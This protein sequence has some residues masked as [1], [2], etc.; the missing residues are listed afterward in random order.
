[1]AI[2][3]P[4][5]EMLADW[6]TATF[7]T[8]PP[9]ELAAATERDIAA[10]REARPEVLVEAADFG[11]SEASEF[12][13]QAAVSKFGYVNE[14]HKLYIGKAFTP[15]Q[16]ADWWSVQTFGSL[17]Y[18][19]VGVHHTAIPDRTT[20]IGLQHL[21]NTFA[22]FKNEHGWPAGKGPH[23][24]LRSAR[25]GKVPGPV[26]YVG[27][28]P[29]SDGIGISYRNF[30]YLHI[31]FIDRFTYYGMSEEDFDLYQY[32]LGIV[33]GQRGIPL[34]HTGGDTSPGRGWD[35]P[36]SPMDG[37]LF[38]RNAKT[39]IKDCPGAMV[40]EVQF[41]K[42]MN[43]A[44]NPYRAKPGGG[45]KPQPAPGGKSVYYVRLKDSLPKDKAVNAL[46]TADAAK[47]EEDRLRKNH[48]IETYVEAPKAPA[49]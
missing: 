15:E 49:G 27:T 39:D 37:Y 34:R 10:L 13:E 33:C 24:W 19:G 32:V 30:R 40:H 11:G 5:R 36:Q 25:A 41:G 4:R 12:V 42:E 46:P 17:P 8:A 18:N 6:D 23:L 38:H 1:M 22:Y 44:S 45:S 16:F 2:G 43:E 14:A 31:E 28:H 3:N 35:G 21:H 47:K 20:W 48:G 9:E 7:T 26:I 29:A